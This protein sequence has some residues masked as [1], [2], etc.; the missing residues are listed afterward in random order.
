[1]S[2]LFRSRPLREYVN[3]SLYVHYARKHLGVRCMPSDIALRNLVDV[4]AALDAKDIAYS[5]ASGTLLGAVREG[6]FIRHDYDV[7]LT[8]LADSFDPGVLPDLRRLGFAIRT[9]IG[10]P[11]DGMY[12][13]LV[14]SDV[15]VDIDFLYPRDNGMYQSSYAD[16]R[17]GTAKWIDYLFPKL[18]YGW[19]E[20]MGHQFR[21]PKEP[22]IV[23][24][25]LYGDSWGT[26]DKNW[27]GSFDPPNAST[28]PERLDLAASRK[29]IAEYIQS[30]TGVPEVW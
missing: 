17:G 7:D 5:L 26:P 16:Y 29:A 13:S 12:L 9:F 14:R 11:D 20:F 28:R 19:M 8:V 23:L 24:R 2:K 21:A 3:L 30:H 4:A 18:N 1:M 15:T 10:F 27:H 22:E 25:C 6:Q